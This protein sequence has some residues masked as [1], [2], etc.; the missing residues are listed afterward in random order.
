MSDVETE[1]KEMLRAK[2]GEAGSARPLPVSTFSRAKRRRIGTAFTTLATV[3]GV[4][5]ASI[6]G[7]NA[8]RR[9]DE[10][11][12]PIDVRPRLTHTV[13]VGGFAE[14]VV[15]GEGAAWVTRRGAEPGKDANALLRIDT[16]SGRIL[17]TITPGASDDRLAGALGGLAVGEG[18]VWLVASPVGEGPRVV[19]T[20]SCSASVVPS[21]SA[22]GPQP[23]CSTSF[24]EQG[25]PVPQ[26]S[27]TVRASPIPG[28][29]GSPTPSVTLVPTRPE[30]DQEWRVLRIDPRTNEPK[31]GPAVRGWQP[32]NA[33]AGEGAVW[34]TGGFIDSGAVY[35]LDPGS[36]RLVETI[37]LNGFPA[38]V[39]V[40]E[41]SVWVAVTGAGTDSGYVLRIDP[42]TNREIARIPIPGEGPLDLAIGDEGVWTIA[43][44]QGFD[45]PTDLL[46]IDP[47][48]NQL[49]TRIETGLTSVRLAVGAGLVWLSPFDAG[50]LVWID[51]STNTIEGRFAYPAGRPGGLAVD[52]RAVW[53]TG[54]PSERT[55][56]RFALES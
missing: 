47:A 9:S 2:A 28:P 27:F 8:L 21:G 34:M 1:I 24:E 48:T 22:T 16:R 37:E 41:G 18:A 23:Q 30:P 10:G 45:G 55:V 54:V 52:D 53:V 13:N 44:R 40:G 14:D 25:A 29:I 11:I 7:I 36:M 26:A 3:A 35:R 49:A 15:L 46:R 31:V 4:V 33:A 43:F 56:S 39:V 42:K 20:F 19:G 50:D 12:A 51:P 6:T 17:A 5:A 32:S 38:E